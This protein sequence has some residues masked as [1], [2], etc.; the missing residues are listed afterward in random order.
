M[1]KIYSVIFG[2]LFLAFTACE[3]V[4]APY[5]VD[6]DGE[7]EDVEEIVVDP[8][9]SGTLA[10]P[11]NVAG[12]LEYTS[13]LEADK[14]T[15]T[16]VYFKGY[17]T[18]FKSGE[19]PGNSYGNATYYIADTPNGTNTFYVFRG[20]YFGGKSFTSAD[21]LKVG[22]EV[23][24]CSNVVNYKGNTPETVQKECEVVAINGQGEGGGDA[25][26]PTESSKESPLTVEAAQSASGNAYVKGF[27]VGYVNG[28]GYA[29]ATFGAA[30]ADET[31]L[32]LAATADE[33]DATKCI[34]V[35][36]PSGDI[37]T[38]LNP[39]K[40]ENIGQEVVVYGSLEKYFG[41]TGVKSTSWAKFGGKEYGKDPEGGDEGSVDNGPVAGSGTAQ[42]PYNVAAVIAKAS[43][44]ASGAESEAVYF[45]G[46]V[47]SFKANEEPGNS[48]GNATFYVSDTNGAGGNSFLVYRC[49][50]YSGEK[51]TSADQLKVGDEVV[52]YSPLTNY[53]GNTPETVQKKGQIYLINGVGE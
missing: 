6:W 38:A 37:R 11:F 29:D 39:S 4:P 42:D 26:T 20:M 16:K 30:A 13:S 1:K 46:Y 45:K 31:E 5:G 17:V 50:Y 2:A 47:T 27:I 40:A 24:L 53:M 9:G 34:P 7:G 43:A 23:L 18:S 36:L 48:Y 49:M 21:Q 8:A 25:P 3:N 41:V 35:Q 44:L 19:E 12:I 10:D 51:F 52:I 33:T 15:T 22:D 14:N 28:M 32:L